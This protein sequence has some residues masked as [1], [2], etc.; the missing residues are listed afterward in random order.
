MFVPRYAWVTE[1]LRCPRCDAVLSDLVW[2]AW[3]GL[4]TADPKRGPVYV[5]G[6]HLLWFAD[7]NGVAQDDRYWAATSTGRREGVNFG[8]PRLLDVDV[9]ELDGEDAPR[10]CGSCG[11]ALQGACVSIRRGAIASV[12]AVAEGAVDEGLL[13]VVHDSTTG[14]VTDRLPTDRPIIEMSRSVEL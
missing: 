12:A 9:Y 3:G 11:L 10:L 4:M 7:A 13:A 1:E 6:D 14:R 2:F 5:V 8:D